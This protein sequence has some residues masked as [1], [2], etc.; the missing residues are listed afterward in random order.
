MTL[1]YAILSSYGIQLKEKLTEVHGLS[2]FPHFLKH[3]VLF[4]F[5]DPIQ[6]TR[7]H[8]VTMTP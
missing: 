2:I 3:N 7:A 4:L 6:D 1:L 8:V 5:Q